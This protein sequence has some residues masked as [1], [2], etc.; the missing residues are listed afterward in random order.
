MVNLK[1]IQDFLK[2][3]ESNKDKM[4]Y[5]KDLLDEIEDKKLIEEIKKLIEEIKKIDEIAQIEI[6]GK[7]QWSLPDEEESRGERRLE[8][9]VA[10]VRLPEE[11]K[12][13]VEVKFS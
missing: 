11:E 13:K 6:R 10:F 3:I 4:N 12:K 8:K 5:L 9:Q 7:V 2:K 1:E